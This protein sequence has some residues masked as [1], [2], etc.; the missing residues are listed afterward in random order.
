MNQMRRALELYRWSEEESEKYGWK[1][2]TI[3]DLETIER[4]HIQQDDF[5]SD[6]I[7]ESPEIMKLL[8]FLGRTWAIDGKPLA[9]GGLLPTCAGVAEMWSV[10]SDAGL[11]RPK[12]LLRFAKHFIQ[13]AEG[14]L[15]LHRIGIRCN[16]KLPEPREFA[17]VLGFQVEGLIRHMPK[18]GDE[19]W[20]MARYS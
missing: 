8:P 6:A 19:H 12:T 4:S 15:S 13:V 20:L 11:K 14:R 1:P 2:L 3:E 10:I 7:Y 5:G 18:P 9:V 17:E 16:A